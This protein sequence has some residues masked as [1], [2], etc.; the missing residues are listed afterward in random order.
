MNNP[1]QSL[2]DALKA[3]RDKINELAKSDKLVWAKHAVMALIPDL[4]AMTLVAIA[5]GFTPWLISCLVLLLVAHAVKLYSQYKLA[6]Q[7]NINV[8]DMDVD[9]NKFIK[10][11]VAALAIG[12]V[13][14]LSVI[15]LPAFGHIACWIAIA[16]TLA[17]AAIEIAR[18]AVTIWQIW[19]LPRDLDPAQQQWLDTVAPSAN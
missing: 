16:G 4:I 19:N 17:F 5:I 6:Q 1:K 11:C 14:L 7:N 15:F 18:A 9:M 12:A 2:N 3:S 13:C 10:H 8:T